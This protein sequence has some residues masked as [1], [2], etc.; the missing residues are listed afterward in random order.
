MALRSI[1]LLRRKKIF[2]EEEFLFTVPIGKTFGVLVDHEHIIVDFFLH[3]LSRREWRG[4]WEVRRS[5]LGEGTIRSFYRGY[6]K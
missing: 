5:D 2:K 4:P 1:I 6:K 3:L